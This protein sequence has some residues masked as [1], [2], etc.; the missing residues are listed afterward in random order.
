[1]GLPGPLKLSCS[2]SPPTQWLSWDLDMGTAYLA[3]SCL[4]FPLPAPRLGVIRGRSPRR[5]LQAGVQYS[6]IKTAPADTWT[7]LAN[8][9]KAG[10]WHPSSHTKVCTRGSSRVLGL[11]P[12]AEEAWQG[13]IAPKSLGLLGQ[14]MKL[15]PSPQSLPP[16][17]P[18]ASA[19]RSNI[20]CL[21]GAK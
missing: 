11:C 15:P 21:S 2:T 20:H 3:A 4:L 6:G 19:R 10:K 17:L 18:T 5:P 9:S 13:K 16:P 8:E 7:L 12:R 1:M 14:G